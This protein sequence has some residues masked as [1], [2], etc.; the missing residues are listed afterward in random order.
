MLCP[1]VSA[2]SLVLGA[3]DLESSLEAQLQ[4]AREV[5]E[6]ER[7]MEKRDRIVDLEVGR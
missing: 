1:S 7:D 4:H 2:P 6:R 5:A 3:S